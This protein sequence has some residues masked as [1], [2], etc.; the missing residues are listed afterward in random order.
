[1]FSYGL[2]MHFSVSNFGQNNFLLSGE[3]IICIVRSHI[4]TQKYTCIT[5]T[6][7]I[8]I[9]IFIFCMY[10]KIGIHDHIGTIHTYILS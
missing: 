10:N 9:Y 1:M 2:S 3:A 8:Y 7:H 4:Y 6:M 5:H